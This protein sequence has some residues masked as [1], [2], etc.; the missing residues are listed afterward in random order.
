[1]HFLVLAAV[2][3]FGDCRFSV[4]RLIRAGDGEVG[5][6]PVLGIDPENEIQAANFA[7]RLALVIKQEFSQ[8]GS[9]NVVGRHV[10]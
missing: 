6:C 7:L 2:A 9:V 8:T 4:L 1:M 10:R 5:N 3:E